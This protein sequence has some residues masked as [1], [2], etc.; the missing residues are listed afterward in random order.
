M[1]SPLME[2]QCL[3]CRAP[4][5]ERLAYKSVVIDSGISRRP[6]PPKDGS[7]G[8]SRQWFRRGHMERHR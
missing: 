8:A 4:N 1:S 5:L 3:I 2:K 6:L 7:E